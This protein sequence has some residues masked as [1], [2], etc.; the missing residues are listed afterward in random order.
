MTE[1]LFSVSSGTVSN[2]VGGSEVPSK[3]RWTDEKVSVRSLEDV[4]AVEA[5]RDPAG[6]LDVLWLYVP[7]L[8]LVFLLLFLFLFLPMTPMRRCSFRM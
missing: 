3:V 4:A 5:G 6:L 8:S 2:G 7:M 1:S